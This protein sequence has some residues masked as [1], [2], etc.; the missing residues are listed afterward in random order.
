M[1][2][3]RIIHYFSVI[4]YGYCPLN[5][6]VKYK[7]VAKYLFI[8]PSGEKVEKYEWRANENQL[9]ACALCE[10]RE[11]GVEKALEGLELVGRH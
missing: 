5:R 9:S 4:L 3:L 8:G 10:I 1:H 11:P 2:C 6:R 7:P